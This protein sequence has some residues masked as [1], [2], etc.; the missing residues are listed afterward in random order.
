MGGF[1]GGLVG[2]LVGDLVGSFMGGLVGGFGG[3]TARRCLDLP[4]LSGHWAQRFGCGGCGSGCG[5]LGSLAAHRHIRGATAVGCLGSSTANSG[6]LLVPWL[7]LTPGLKLLALQRRGAGGGGREYAS[8][9]FTLAQGGR[10]Y[11]FVIKLLSLVVALGPAARGV[12][13]RGA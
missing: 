2:G 12:V 4:R 10:L 9:S 1:V 3:A 8:A 5:N 6:M 13:C 11:D 7:L